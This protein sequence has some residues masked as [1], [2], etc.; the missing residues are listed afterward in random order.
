MKLRPRLRQLS[1][2]L[3]PRTWALDADLRRINRYYKPLVAQAKGYQREYLIQQRAEERAYV[4][5]GFV[6][7]QTQRLLR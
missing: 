4:E 1:R 3:L 5:E 7:I 2:T 6:G